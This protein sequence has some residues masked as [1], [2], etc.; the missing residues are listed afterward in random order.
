MFESAFKKQLASVTS[1]ENLIGK[2]W[3][4][5]RSQYSKSNRHYHN[6]SHL[7]KITELLSGIAEK[8][9]DWQTLV[10]SI[11]YHDVIYD[12][13]KKDNEEKSGGYA[14]ERLLELGLPE[15]QRNKCVSQILATKR[16]ETSDDSD[17]NYFTDADLAVLG[18]SSEDYK[19][20]TKW[21]RKEYK[22]Y[23]DLIY[24]PW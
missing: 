3:D 16:H 9:Q 17:T 19:Q 4:E 24:K 8:I 18:F 13:L 11:A 12:V 10:F 23:P 6:L 7:N 15:G 5:V 22:F 21:I 2:L 20:Y 1:D 14:G